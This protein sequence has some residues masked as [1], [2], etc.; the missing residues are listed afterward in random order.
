MLRVYSV[1]LQ[2]IPVLAVV[3][4]AACGSN[5]PAKP[6][7]GMANPASVH[8]GKVG[9]ELRIESLGDRGEIGVCYFEDGRQ[10]EEWALFRGE[11]PVGGRRV[12]GFVTERARYCAIRGGRYE[13]TRAETATE[14]ERGRCSLPDGSVCAAAGAGSGNC[15]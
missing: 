3:L 15:P 1:W 5:A 6:K 10:C 11:C 7:L 13:M 8:C 14:P 9:G 4:L 2:G 12:T